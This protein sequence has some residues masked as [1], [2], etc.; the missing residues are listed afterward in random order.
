MTRALA[1][2]IAQLAAAGTF[3]LA[4]HSALALVAELDTFTIVKNGATLFQDDFGDGIAPPAAPG[5]YGE[6][7]T[8]LFPVGTITEKNGKAYLNA[9]LGELRTNAQGALS[10]VTRTTFSTNIVASESTGLKSTQTFSVSA[11]YSF[12]DVMSEGETYGIRLTDRDALGGLGIGS[13]GDDV[14]ELRINRSQADITRLQFR[15]QDFIAHEIEVVASFN[16]TSLLMNYENVELKLIKDVV[17]SNTIKASATFID[18]QG[19][20]E[21]QIVNFES[22]TDAFHGE[23]WT[24]AELFASQAPIPEPETYA[25]LLTGLALVGWQL[26]RKSRQGRKTTIG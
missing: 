19:V 3:A 22:T 17:G 8:Y 14:I 18:L 24:R 4:S 25:M 12:L 7:A 9:A 21:N 10:S 13:S 26:Q 20:L 15:R 1:K 2:R 6:F 23:N 16:A 11:T 5:I